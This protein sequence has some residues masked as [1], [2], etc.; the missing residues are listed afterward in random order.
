MWPRWHR[1]QSGSCLANR[2]VWQ[3]FSYTES[4]DRRHRAQSHRS[5]AE[6]IDI[7]MLAP[8]TMR[9]TATIFTDTKEQSLPHNCGIPYETALLIA[10]SVK[11]SLFKALYPEAGC[12]LALTPRGFAPSNPQRS[13]SPSN[14]RNL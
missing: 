10:F 9:E 14:S 6:G 4:R 13:V 12:F 11:E 1:R 8:G 5:Y 2:L 7:E 3:P